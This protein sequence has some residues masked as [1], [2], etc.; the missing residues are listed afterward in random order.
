MKYRTF[1]KTG[2]KVAEVALGTWQLGSRWGDPFDD[3]VARETLEEATK[4]GI[5]CY[6]T[7]DV[8]QGGASEVAIG[9]Y[10]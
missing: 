8:Y 5:N 7:A 10:I 3:K 1:G 2:V 4:Y 9:K 6:D